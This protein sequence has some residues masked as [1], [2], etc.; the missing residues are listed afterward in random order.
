MSLQNTI[1][2]KIVIYEQ[3]TCRKPS[4]IIMSENDYKKFMIELTKTV[5]IDYKKVT[6]PKFNG[7]RIIRS[8][9][10]ENIEVY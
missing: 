1:I 3:T 9:D 4:V 7:I 5:N 6:K 10:S 2:E 8:K